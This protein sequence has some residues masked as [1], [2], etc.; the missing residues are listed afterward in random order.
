M[1]DKLMTILKKFPCNCKLLVVSKH[2]ELDTCDIQS[3][4]IFLK[5]I[6]NPMIWNVM[7]D[8]K[9]WLSEFD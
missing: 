3:K 4:D 5:I 1:Y 6:P 8:E 7:N 2:K 9:V